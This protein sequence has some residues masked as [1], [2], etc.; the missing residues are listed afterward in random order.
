MAWGAEGHEIVALIALR[1][2]TPAA[3]SQVARLLGGD[4]MMVHDANWADEIRDQRRDT[5]P[6][7]YVDIPLD[8]PGYDA[9]RDC[10]QRRLRGGADRK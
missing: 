1:E 8:A 7:H 6:W 9:R 2:L 5:G 4:A 3:R 10:P